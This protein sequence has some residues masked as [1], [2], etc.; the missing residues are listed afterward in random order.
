VTKQVTVLSG[1]GVTVG[2]RDDETNPLLAQYRNPQGMATDGSYL[3]IADEDNNC[4]R[5]VA[6]DG[7]ATTTWAGR[8]EEGWDVSAQNGERNIARFVHPMCVVY[9][10]G[11]FYV[12]DASGVR[13][14]RGDQVGDIT[15][16]RTEGRG[17][18]IVRPGCVSFRDDCEMIVPDYGGNRVFRLLP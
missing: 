1:D 17:G 7:G 8:C 14:V 12:S 6:I 16:A 11:T 3:Y 10:K 18:E 5:R 9:R 2:Y 4:L 13:T 15:A